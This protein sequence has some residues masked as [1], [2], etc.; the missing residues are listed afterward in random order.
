MLHGYA[1][2]YGLVCELYLS[3]VRMGF[4]TETL[5]QT[6]T[7]IRTYYGTPSITCDDYPILIQLMHHDKKNR[8]NEI[9][10]TLLS[11]IGDIHVDQSISEDEV[12]EALDFLREG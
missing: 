12:T 8:G 10:V 11:D 4:P 7:F 5:R 2:A 9:N 1:V 3:A 6:A